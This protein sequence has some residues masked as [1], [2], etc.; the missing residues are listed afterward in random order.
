MA[1]PQPDL[2]S[3]RE[4]YER[5]VKE[6]R[7]QGHEL[8]HAQ[9]YERG[10]REGQAKGYRDGD[11]QGHK[12]GYD[13][14]YAAA[15][16]YACTR[17]VVMGGLDHQREPTP[18]MWAIH[19]RSLDDIKL[20][21]KMDTNFNQLSLPVGSG[22]GSPRLTPLRA[23]IERNDTAIVNLLLNFNVHMEFA[24]P[25]GSNALLAAASEGKE[26]I[27]HLLFEHGAEELLRHHYKGGSL[28]GYSPLSVAVY[29][30]HLPVV[31]LL[32]GKMLLTQTRHPSDEQVLHLA[33]KRGHFSIVNYLLDE[34]YDVNRTDENKQTPLHAAISA[35]CTHI[36]QLLLSQGAHTEVFDQNERTP[37]QLAIDRASAADEEQFCDAI[38]TLID[39]GAQIEH[40]D[41]RYSALV[42]AARLGRVFCVRLLLGKKADPN[43]IPHRRTRMKPAL[44]E[45]IKKNNLTITKILLEHGGKLSIKNELCSCPVQVG[46]ENG[47]QKMLEVLLK[48][49]EHLFLLSNWSCTGYGLVRLAIENGQVDLIPFLLD[50][51][52]DIE[53]SSTNDELSEFRPLHSAVMLLNHEAV[54]ILLERGA[55]PC[56][57][58]KTGEC[59]KCIEVN[60]S[61]DGL[62]A[63]CLLENQREQVENDSNSRMKLRE[64]DELIRKKAK[65]IGAAKVPKHVKNSNRRNNGLFRR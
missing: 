57:K 13:E 9:G 8:G 29:H 63:R 24:D 55:D 65:E 56:S 36:L 1:P 50:N 19:H 35:G 4:E 30:G 20:L 37:M 33:S 28:C 61:S 58:T 64:I 10:F 45:A 3:L 46:I 54:C 27:V 22:I 40:T 16:E 43:Y 49:E 48:Q 6:G 39:N 7:A 5:G 15:L 53:F 62:Y 60:G 34:K 25:D 31:K 23:A 47:N 18:T 52:A 26:E 51:G 12:A 59:A 17:F 11:I 44:H 32:H 38:T 14:G 2:K 42:Y 21:R 41:N